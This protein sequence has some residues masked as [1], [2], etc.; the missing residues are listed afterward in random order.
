MTSPA[1]PLT[2]ELSQV[3]GAIE[4]VLEVGKQDMLIKGA[5][6]CLI[7]GPNAHML[8][9]LMLQVRR[10]R[11]RRRKRRKMNEFIPKTG[12]EC[13]RSRGCGEGW[14]LRV[15]GVGRRTRGSERQTRRAR[16]ERPALKIPSG[17][18]ALFPYWCLLMLSPPSSRLPAPSHT[19]SPSA[20]LPPCSCSG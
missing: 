17:A 13:S 20:V 16:A 9:P 11:R 14:V 3:L 4:H 18:S 6:A 12:W 10:R 15:H 1:G 8:E 7:V 5:A 2:Y 19:A